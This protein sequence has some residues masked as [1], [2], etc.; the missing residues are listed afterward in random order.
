MLWFP[1]YIDDFLASKKVLH[2]TIGEQGAYLR[3]LMMAWSDVH[4]SLPSHMKTLQQMALWTA[5]TDGTWK[6]VR[7]C[8]TKHPDQPAR[9]YNARLYAEWVNVEDLRA[10]RREA[11]QKRWQKP[12]IAIPSKPVDR[13]STGLESIA[14]IADKHFPP[15]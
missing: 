12:S 1:L 13:S 11:S 14:S 8:F 3:L 5:K 2:M 15:K 7:E 4:C 10:Q 6:K 9:L